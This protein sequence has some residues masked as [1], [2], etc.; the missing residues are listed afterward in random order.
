[1]GNGISI[2]VSRGQI[3]ILDEFVRDNQPLEAC[4]ILLGKRE[5]NAFVIKEIVPAQNRDSSIVRFTIDDDMLFEIYKLAD[6]K[7]LSV[8]GIFHSHPSEPYPS[9][10]DKSYMKVNPVPW[11]IKSTTT[12]EMRCFISS[13]QVNDNESQIEEIEIKIR[14]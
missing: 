14:D 10:T 7:N 5:S 13:D 4:A 1:M 6:K 12:D 11:I 3:S 2:L 9:S 8:V